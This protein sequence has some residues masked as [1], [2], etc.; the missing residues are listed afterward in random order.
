MS[1]RPGG[2]GAGRFSGPD[3]PPLPGRETSP[4]PSRRSGWPHLLNPTPQQSRAAMAIRENSCRNPGNERP[5]V[6][7]GPAARRDTAMDPPGEPARDE[8]PLAEHRCSGGGFLLACRVSAPDQHPRGTLPWI[9]I[10]MRAGPRSGCPG[11]WPRVASPVSSTPIRPSSRRRRSARPRRDGKRSEASP[12]PRQRF[13]PRGRRPGRRRDH[14][15]RGPAQRGAISGLG[16]VPE[17]RGLA[18]AVPRGRLGGGGRSLPGSSTSKRTRKSRIGTTPGSHSR[19]T[20]RRA[21]SRCRSPS[22]SRRIASDMSGSWT[23]CC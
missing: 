3:G 15:K 10:A 17:G 2:F 16:P 5:R 22:T 14:E 20:C 13:H 23:A 21:R 18:R 6:P 9:S 8:W 4:R 1:I 12:G 11:R 19:P 7:L